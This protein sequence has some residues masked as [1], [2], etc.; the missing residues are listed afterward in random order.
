[1]SG[2]DLVISPSVKSGVLVKQPSSPSLI[3][4]DNLHHEKCEEIAEVI[5]GAER[6]YLVCEGVSMSDY[7]YVVDRLEE[8]GIAKRG[9]SV[10]LT[11]A[12]VQP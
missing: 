2:E 12:V 1:M 7:K 8:V 5:L 9:T 6:E 3:Q 10:S 11:M 4:L